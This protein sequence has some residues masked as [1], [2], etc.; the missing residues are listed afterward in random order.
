M[1]E[2]SPYIKMEALFDVM[3]IKNG[4]WRWLLIDKVAFRLDLLVFYLIVNSK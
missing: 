2:I 3:S 4:V 1:Q